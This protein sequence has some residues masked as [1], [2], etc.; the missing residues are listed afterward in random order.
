VADD[1]A[2]KLKSGPLK[3]QHWENLAEFFEDLTINSR[4]VAELI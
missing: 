2:A 1:S 3:S 4:Q